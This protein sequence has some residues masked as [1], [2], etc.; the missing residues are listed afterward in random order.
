MTGTS[1]ISALI[2][3]IAIG[4]VGRLVAFGR[5]ALPTWLTLALGVA[6]ALL[7]SVTARLAGADLD[8]LTALR[9]VVQ[10]GFASLAVLLAVVTAGRRRPGDRARL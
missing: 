1:L 10:S 7:G 6:A 3:G 5:T 4:M 8:G 9:L 2:V